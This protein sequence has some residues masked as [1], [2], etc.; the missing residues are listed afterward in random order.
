MRK[1]DNELDQDLR[2]ATAGIDAGIELQRSRVLHGGV[3]N[4]HEG[5]SVIMEEFL[6]LQDIV[7]TRPEDQNLAAM[8]KEAIQLAAMALKFASDLTPTPGRGDEEG[9]YGH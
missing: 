4:A 7:F 9:A 8:R 3:S 2:D 1:P 6:E 5:H